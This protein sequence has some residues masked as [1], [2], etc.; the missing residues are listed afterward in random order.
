MKS[1][2]QH[3]NEKKLAQFEKEGGSLG[4]YLDPLVEIGD[5]ATIQAINTLTSKVFGHANSHGIGNP[6]TYAQ[7]RVNKLM[8]LTYGFSNTTLSTFFI[9][10]GKELKKVSDLMSVMTKAPSH[11]GYTYVVPFGR[12]YFILFRGGDDQFGYFDTA[13][14]MMMEFEDFDKSDLVKIDKLR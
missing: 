3:L 10:N 11:D 12:G 5:A 9:L 6:N 1:F 13:R 8:T 4:Y 2:T 7:V 14:K